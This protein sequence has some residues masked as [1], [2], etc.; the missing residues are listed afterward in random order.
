M[1]LQVSRR[2]VAMPGAATIAAWQRAYAVD[3]CIRVRGFVEPALLAWIRGRIAAARFTEYVHADMTPPCVDLLLNDAQLDLMFWSLCNDA[4]LFEAVERITGCA[5]I[6]C[7]HSRVYAMDPSPDHFDTWHDDLEE[8]NRLVAMSVN[9]G[10]EY[11]GGLLRLRDAHSGRLVHE[12]ANTGPGDAILFRIH[13]DLQHIVTPVTGERRK[14]ALA[15]WFQ[16]R[17]NALHRIRTAAGG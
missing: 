2:G 10:G 17:P 16:R 7:Y 9:L 14:I 15:G 1:S 4:R 8:D 6:G 5:P 11:D 13:E 3:H 12:V